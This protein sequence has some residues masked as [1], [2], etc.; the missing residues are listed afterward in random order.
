VKAGYARTGD[1]ADRELYKKTDDTGLQAE[2]CY[3]PYGG[4]HQATE[5]K[6]GEELSAGR[7]SLCRMEMGRSCR[8]D[9]AKMAIRAILG[10]LAS[11]RCKQSEGLRDS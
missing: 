9:G 2:A 11:I 4:Q 10:G 7:G 5:T 6:N 3:Y 8:Q 1:K